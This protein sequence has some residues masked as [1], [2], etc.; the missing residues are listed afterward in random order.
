LFSFFQ[1]IFYNSLPI[2]CIVNIVLN[3]IITLQVLARHMANTWW[4]SKC[5]TITIL[6]VCGLYFTPGVNV[7][8]LVHALH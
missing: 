6:D 5:Q 4:P 7:V 3:I 1:W 2:N 8:F